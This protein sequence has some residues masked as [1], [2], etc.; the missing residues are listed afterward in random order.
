MLARKQLPVFRTQTAGQENICYL[1]EGL[2]LAAAFIEVGDSAGTLAQNMLGD[3]KVK[4]FDEAQWTFSADQ[5]RRLLS[6]RGS[7]YG[8][9][10]YGTPGTSSYRTYIPFWFDQPWMRPQRDGNQGVN[11][12]KGCNPQISVEVES[13]ITT[14]VLQGWFYYRD[15]NG[16]LALMTRFKRQSVKVSGTENDHV[17]LER[18]DLL[19]GIHLFP[20]DDGGYVNKVSLSLNNRTLID[21]LT[22][23]QNQAGLLGRSWY[24]DTTAT[25]RFDLLFDDEDPQDLGLNTAKAT[26]FTLTTGYSTT[27]SGTMDVILET[28]GKPDGAA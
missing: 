1:S 10:T 13:G 24:P 11:L 28:I 3:V 23:L 12:V 18:R 6:L 25:P 9:Q 19:Q 5:Y 21:K 4:L 16:G 27:V 20:P 26:E 14:P 2:N 8:F 15:L 7:A 22:H 17:E